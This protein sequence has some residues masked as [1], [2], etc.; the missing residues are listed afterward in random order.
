MAG[1]ERRAGENVPVRLNHF[2]SQRR[3]KQ[4]HSHITNGETIS[5]TDASTAVPAGLAFE[6]GGLLFIFYFIGLN[7]L[8]KAFDSPLAPG[9]V[10]ALKM[11]VACAS[12]VFLAFGL[13]GLLSLGVTGSGRKKVLG[14]TGTVV[15]LLGL[16]SYIVGSIY[17]YN[18]PERAQFFTPG[19]S[20]LIM[21][22]MLLLGG[23]RARGRNIA[24]LARGHSAAGRSLLPFAVSTS[25][26][27]F[28]EAGQG[29]IAD[30]A[31]RVGRASGFCSAPQCT[32]AVE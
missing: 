17:I 6:T 9:T 32:Q 10:S 27:V 24:R 2:E 4:L 8:L 16:T 20:A 15:A 31:R 19:G 28:P 29:T 11:S 3:T 14:V 7:P 30:A 18:F 5:M 22:G 23:G 1:G 26:D 25:G 21:L 13:F 12:S